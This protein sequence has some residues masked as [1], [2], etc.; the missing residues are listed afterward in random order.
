MEKENVCDWLGMG[1]S[2]L[3]MLLCSNVL[4]TREFSILGV[5]FDAAIWGSLEA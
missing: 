2:G 5:T 4:I 3:L 1:N